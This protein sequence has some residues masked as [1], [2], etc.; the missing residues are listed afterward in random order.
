VVCYEIIRESKAIEKYISKWDEIFLSGA[1]E[2]SLSTDWTWA[3]LN[4]HVEDN[5]FIL[6]VLKNSQKIFGIVPLVIIKTSKYGLSYLTVMPVSEYYNT[7]SD[8]LLMPSSE[9]LACV[10]ID[11]LHSLEEKW[12]VFRIK[13]VI[14]SNMHLQ[15]IENY[16]NANSIKYEINCEDPSYFIE[17]NRSYDSY[18][19]NRPKR[20][21]VNLKRSEKLIQAMGCVSYFAAEDYNNISAAFNSIL[22]IE[23]NS[24]KHKQGTA[25]TS[26][27]K[28]KKFYSD[29]CES[30]Y[31]K[32]LL[33]LRFLMVN[34]EPAAYRMGVIK[35]NRYFSLKASYHE[36][37]K[38]ASP[39]SVLLAWLIK[40][41][42]RNGI[43]EY[44]FTAEPY[45]WQKNWTDKSR[46]HKSLIIYNNTYKAKLYSIYRALKH[47]IK[48]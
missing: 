39:S 17:L 3:L 27:A 1:Y 26:F 22:Y 5:P 29:F 2:P 13:R 28:Q 14:A 46:S 30:S 45:E 10:F 12:D 18:L 24:W 33:C 34:G 42:I 16:L 19:N 38:K 37:F 23:E 40:D 15:Y 8:L 48:R 9:E 36:K 20:F 32:G 47:K 43:E 35:Q 11:A 6:V 31:K 44:D 21:R 25:I 41:L 4:S 7:H